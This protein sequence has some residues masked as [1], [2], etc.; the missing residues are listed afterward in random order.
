MRIL[1]YDLLTKTCPRHFPQLF[2]SDN[3]VMV[4]AI[5][6]PGSSSGPAFELSVLGDALRLGSP[7]AKGVV[8]KNPFMQKKLEE[9]QE[10]INA[11][12]GQIN[13]PGV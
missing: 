12:L 5:K 8:A 3:S 11:L 13:V 7:S 4:T 2:S 9:M 1:L 6:A 10:E